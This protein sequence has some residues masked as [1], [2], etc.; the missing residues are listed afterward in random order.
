LK[1]LLISHPNEHRQK[2]DFPPIG[3]AYLGAVVYEKGHNVLLIDGG[4]TSIKDI[5]HQA[6]NFAPD[7]IGVTCWTINRGTVWQLCLNLQKILSQ[8]FLAVGGP[9]ASLYPEHIFLKT[10]ATA[11]VIGEGEETICELLEAVENGDDL[12]QIKGIAYRKKDGTVKQT[13]QR[14]QIEQLDSIPF[15]YYARF[16]NFSFQKYGGFAGL[17]RPTAAVITS[18][19]CVF[20]CTYCGSVN[21]WGKK[22]RYRSAENV[23][24]EIQRHVKVMG[25]RSIYIFDDNFPVNKKRAI[26]ICQGIID[27]KL[28]IQWACCSH[29]K[30]INEELLSAM[31]A[32][33][34]VGIDFGVE[35]GSDII[36]KNINKNQNRKDIERAFSLV[37]RAGI[38]PR[39]YLMVGNK[40]ETLGT[41]DET[42]EMTGIINPHSSIGATMLWLLPGT[43]VFDEARENGFI[44]DGYWLRSDDVPYNL[45]EYSY[46]EL[47]GLRQRLMRGIAKQKSGITPMVSFYLK[48]VFYRY[49][50]LSFM[51]SLIPDRLR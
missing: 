5:V 6:K 36:L 20:D 27:R 24:E 50:V 49:P 30:M 18:R 43:R 33:G 9:H 44:D 47:F 38:K 23:L 40:G 16:K 37:H 2:P 34:C 41:I 21:F 15:P 4:L 42:I 7:F 13:A 3:V 1:V 51:R 28:D 10:H 45:Q 14:P 12:A 35:S 32:S 19:G 26:D 22:W 17:P 31:K 11:V 25:T 48:S 46:R 29:V 39:A 8:A